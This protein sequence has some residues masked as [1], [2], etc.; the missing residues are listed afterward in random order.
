[1]IWRSAAY[2]AAPAAMGVPAL[3]SLGGLGKAVA[4][5]AAL[6]TPRHRSRLSHG[7]QR[8]L[9]T[10][11][12]FFVQVIC[13]VCA[14]FLLYSFPGFLVVVALFLA[15]CGCYLVWNR[16]KNLFFLPLFIAVLFAAVAGTAGGITNYELYYIN[17]EFYKFSQ[18]YR[19]IV[20]FSP[21]RSR[22]G[23]IVLASLL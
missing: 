2:C 18:A 7:Q 20:S 12:G 23:T 4:G 3:P 15:T 14:C 19:N 16:A 22:E 13:H 9:Y 21:Q 5:L 10:L 8:L 11:V 1:M 6:D 17:V